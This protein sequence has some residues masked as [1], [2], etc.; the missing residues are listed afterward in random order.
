MAT[1]LGGNQEDEQ[2]VMAWKRETV[3]VREKECNLK[4]RIKRHSS[5]MVTRAA[6]GH[7]SSLRK[8]QPARNPR[9]T[10]DTQPGIRI[11]YILVTAGSGYENF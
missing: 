10:T 5:D 6:A 8:D 11:Y 2:G 4:G 9:G 3:C 1:G 7:P